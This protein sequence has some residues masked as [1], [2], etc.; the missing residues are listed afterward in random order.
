MST[1]NTR[2][3]PLTIERGDD[4]AAFGLRLYVQFLQGLFNWMPP[5]TFHWEPDAETSE[6]VIRAQA[7]LDMKTV[8]KRP[9]ITVVMGPHQ[10]G[11]IGM[12][13]LLKYDMNTGERIR[14]DLLSGHLIVYCI[15]NSDIIAM[16]L[17]HLVAHHTRDSQRLLESKG[18]FHSIARP[19]PSMNSPSPPGQLIMG[20]PQSLIMV[21]VNIPYQ[22]Q[23]TWSNLPSTKS[24]QFRSLDQVTEERRASEYK[25]PESQTVQSM[26]LAMSTKTVLVK[27]LSGSSKNNNV[28]NPSIVTVHEGVEDFQISGLESF[29]DD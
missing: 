25:Y 29:Q 13:N 17:G 18:G 19:S 11:G 23:W 4:P 9:A 26:K 24:P 28:Q 21:Q 7:P 16:R 8:G 12:D 2:R 10:Y 20:D 27:K 1:S 6:I 22:I 15:A 5:G 3:F 14:T